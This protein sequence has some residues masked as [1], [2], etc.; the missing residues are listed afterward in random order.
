M[1]FS[2]QRRT[3]QFIATVVLQQLVIC[4]I[5]R[6]F[7]HAI[8]IVFQM[9][10]RHIKVKIFK[11]QTTTSRIHRINVFVQISIV[12]HANFVISTRNYPIFKVQKTARIIHLVIA[13]ADKLN[14]VQPN[15]FRIR[16]HR[17][18][19]ASFIQ[20]IPFALPLHSA[21]RPRIARNLIRSPRPANIT[22]HR[23]SAITQRRHRPQRRTAKRRKAHGIVIPRKIAQ[24]QNRIRR[25][26]TKINLIDILK[27]S[28]RLLP[29][30]AI[31]IRQKSV[32][33]NAIGKFTLN[34][35]T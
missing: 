15:F 13:I 14:T 35:K 12:F 24:M 11:F 4:T 25:F 21:K 1:Q 3:E 30:L 29:R 16:H 33:I 31:D 18:E 19:S 7:T 8:D 32:Y 20:M 26:D 17:N 9:E 23:V 28:S 27:R 22:A 2:I 5:K 6:F 34:R 10:P